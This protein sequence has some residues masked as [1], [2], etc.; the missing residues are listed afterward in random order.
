M[1]ITPPSDIILDVAQA[2]GK[3]D[4]EAARAR[5][6]DATAA[7]RAGAFALSEP[8]DGGAQSEVTR[9]GKE[10][11]VKFESMVLRNFVQAMLPKEDEAVYGKGLAGDMWK[12]MLAERIADVMA[13]RGGIGIADRVLGDYYMD[14]DRKVAV[15]GVSQ[16]PEREARDAQA[17]L[18]DAMVQEI[19][20]NV[21]K[22]YGQA[23]V[24]G[25]SDD[26]S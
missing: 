7:R 5:L 22:A 11:F 9:K 23:P 8:A 6:A 21:M 1:A 17:M 3:P 10:S 19:Q 16:G 25:R 2:V 24:A 18:S 20:R 26:D 4:L 14:G 15:S 12:S 13:E